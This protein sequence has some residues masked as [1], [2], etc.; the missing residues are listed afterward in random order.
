MDEENST[1]H[2]VE[3]GKNKIIQSKE[4]ILEA[5]NKGDAEGVA[6]NYFKEAK[7]FPPNSNLVQGMEKIKSFW[8]IAM[9]KGIKKA[10]LETINIEASGTTAFEVG[11]YKLFLENGQ[12]ADFGE[13][14]AIWRNKDDGWKLYLHQWN[15]ENP[16]GVGENLNIQLNEAIINECEI[17]NIGCSFINFYSVKCEKCLC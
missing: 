7:L 15:S 3:G 14:V 2:I 6:M 9:Y 5:F 8:K 11:N 10:E 4:K 16:A 12:I 13:Y 17:S 1:L